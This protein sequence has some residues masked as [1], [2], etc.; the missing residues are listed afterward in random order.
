LVEAFD[1]RPSEVVS[2]VGGGGKTTLMFKLAQELLK[3]GKTVITTTTT[4]I[5]EPSDEE[6]QCVI[7]EED[8]ERLFSRLRAEVPRH[9]HVSAARLRP[10]AGK[11]KGLLP[12]S[13]DKILDL[14]LADYIINEADGAAR[15]PIKAPNSTEPVIP[16]S[17]TL[18][19]ALAGMDA[20]NEPLSGEIA[21]RPELITRLSGLAEGGIIG[22]EVIATLITAAEGIAQRSPGKARIVPFLNKIELVARERE[23]QELAVAILSRENASI[24]WVVAGSLQASKPEYNIY[25]PALI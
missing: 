21:L 1:L 15:K 2:L 14:G 16:S 13:V 9:G 3:R 18:V 17:T 8:E 10:T 22:L 19:V 20:L 23:V 24:P 11:L 6:S 12:G 7:V 5:M 4:R 25:K